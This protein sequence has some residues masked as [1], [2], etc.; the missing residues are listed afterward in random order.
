MNYFSEPEMDGPYRG[1]SQK[2]SG[3]YGPGG[4]FQ[5]RYG[6]LDAYYRSS[7][8]VKYN[9]NGPP[10]KPQRFPG[11]LTPTRGLTSA[12]PVRPVGSPVIRPAAYG[13]FLK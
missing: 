11:T 2:P 6:T 12:T 8:R 13:K 9:G 10:A 3:G 1:S 7:D 5:R 4:P